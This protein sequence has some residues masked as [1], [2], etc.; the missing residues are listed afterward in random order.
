MPLPFELWLIILPLP[1][2][3]TR[4]HREFY[5]FPVRPADCDPLLFPFRD[6][7]EREKYMTPGKKHV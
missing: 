4:T 5:G 1:E 3:T 6:K 2:P 7:N